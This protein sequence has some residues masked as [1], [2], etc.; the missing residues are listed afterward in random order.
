MSIGSFWPGFWRP[1]K[2]LQLIRA[3]RF[4]FTAS[5]SVQTGSV[6]NDSSHRGRRQELS[7]QLRPAP[8]QPH[9]APALVG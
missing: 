7:G 6:E 1:N 2:S 3:A 9:S 4:V 5:A 8:S